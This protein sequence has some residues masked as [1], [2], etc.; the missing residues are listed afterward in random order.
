METEVREQ[1]KWM[2][3]SRGEITEREKRLKCA[4]HLHLG[5]KKRTGQPT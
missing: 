2:E 5:H 3:E 4:G 1:M